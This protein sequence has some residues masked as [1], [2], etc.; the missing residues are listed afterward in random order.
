MKEETPPAGGERR[1]A[2]RFPIKTPM[3]FRIWNEEVWQYG[4]T[5]NISKA[6]IYFRCERRAESGD[7]MEVE[8]VLPALQ[9]EGSGAWVVCLGEVVRFET[10]LG[11]GALPS[12][13]VKFLY[14]Q[15]LPH[16]DVPEVPS[17]PDGGKANDA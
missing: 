11:T 12:L 1:G 16:K 7:R 9:R 14:S 8:F 5:E 13:A 10:S 3:S 4:T 2:R 17:K 6:G 15:V